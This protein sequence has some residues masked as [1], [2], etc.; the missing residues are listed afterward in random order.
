M[1][2]KVD[3]GC[4]CVYVCDQE[5]TKAK[6]G[7]PVTLKASFTNPCPIPLT[8]CQF[9]MYGSLKVAD[10]DTNGFTFEPYFWPDIGTYTTKLK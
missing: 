6:S 7:Q 4:W 2:S 1:A 9:K 10:D 8:H 3:H 5:N